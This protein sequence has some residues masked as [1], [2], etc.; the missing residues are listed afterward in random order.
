MITNETGAVRAGGSELPE[1]D[2][3]SI[4][5]SISLPLGTTCPASLEV[6]GCPSAHDD[7]C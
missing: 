7:G 5:E 4:I 3:R 2:F 6:Y 1:E